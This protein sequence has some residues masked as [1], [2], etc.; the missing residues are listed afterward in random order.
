MIRTFRYPLLPNASQRRTLE[1]WLDLCRNLYNAALE[2]RRDA[3]ARQRRSVTYNDQTADFTQLRG[4]DPD[5]SAMP[6]IACR[7]ALRRLHRAFQAFFRRCKRGEKPGYP[8]FKAR[9]RYDSIDLG[10]I[11]VEGNRVRVPKLGWVKFHRY[12]ELRGEIL[13][14]TIRRSPKRWWVSISCDVG[15][16]PKK[17]AV[18]T[19]TGIDL[20]LRSFAVLSDGETVENPRHFRQGEKV[21]ARRQQSLSRKPKGSR[22]RQRARR[23]VGLAH[24]HV[25]NQRLDFHRKLA[26]SLT[27]RFDLISHEDLNIRGISRGL[28]LAKSVHDAS[29]GQFIRILTQK[30][31]EAA[32]WVIPVDPYGT[33]QA[34]SRCGSIVP[35][36]LAERIHSC[37][38]GLRLGRDHNAAINILRL[39]RSLVSRPS[40]PE[41]L[42]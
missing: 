7:L 9:D 41:G 21:L 37:S 8:R 23:L 39:G 22:G 13:T 10:K 2:Q 16:A 4:A 20:G 15:P 27:D 40:G 6:Y 1:G 36:T 28:R 31:E 26:K 5:Y 32:A 19:A 14:A 38:C 34:C 24:E 29:W 18:R 35:K 42:N 11:R 12:R 33:T 3:W 17:R 25:R 30:A